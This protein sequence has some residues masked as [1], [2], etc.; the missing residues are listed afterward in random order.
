MYAIEK[1]SLLLIGSGILQA[2]GGENWTDFLDSIN[3]RK[4]ELPRV[5]KIDCPSPL[6][7]IL[8]TGDHVDVAMKNKFADPTEIKGMDQSLVLVL[9]GILSVG[10]DHILTTNY[11]YELETA[12]MHPKKLTKYKLSKMQK[13]TMDRA[14][15][16]YLL[17]TYM[18]LPFSDKQNKLWHI[19]GE[20]RKPE[21][22][23]LG[24]YYY[25]NLLYKIKKEVEKIDRCRWGEENN[26][27]ASWV[28]AFLFGDIYCLG[29]G[30]G[31]CEF[32]LW[33]LLNRKAREKG[34]T[35]K[36]F[37]YDPMVPGDFDAKLDLLKL[38]KSTSGNPIVEHLSMGFEKDNMQDG[39][40]KKFYLAAIEDIKEK[41]LKEK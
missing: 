15:P 1:P 16:K 14:E 11:T 31:L 3:T 41:V 32:D 40:Y 26:T 27:S 9:Q 34:N 19:H 22:V 7:A 18:D 30:L 35:G 39:D 29:F 13:S 28:D 23:V 10:F 17:H 25:G 6:K 24:H 33:W 37:F 12:A 4:D 5:D 21:S 20:A 36:M 2:F 38:L 8:V